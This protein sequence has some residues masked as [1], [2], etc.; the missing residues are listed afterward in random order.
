MN[1]GQEPFFR[2]MFKSFGYAFRGIVV[3]LAKPSNAWIHL[4]V[5]L[6]TCLAGIWF[7]INKTEWIMIILAIALVMLAEMFNSAL[8]TLTDLVSPEFHPLAGK[9]KDIAA[10]AVLVAALGAFL[11]GCLIFIPYLTGR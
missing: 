8:E 11:V 1:R 9:A 2:R 3:F 10:G 7:Q 5:A 6:G 4:T